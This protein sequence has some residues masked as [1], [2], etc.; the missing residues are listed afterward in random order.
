LKRKVPPSYSR[1]DNRARSS[2]GHR[3]D[4]IT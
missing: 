2:N 1:A 3:D 4:E